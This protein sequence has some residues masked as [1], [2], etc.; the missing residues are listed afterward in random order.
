M[1]FKPKIQLSPDSIL[2]LMTPSMRHII[3]LQIQMAE[4]L[5]HRPVILAAPFVVTIR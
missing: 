3:G 2:R 1:A 5:Q 4:L